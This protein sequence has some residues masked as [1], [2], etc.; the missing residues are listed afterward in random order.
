[1]VVAVIICVLVHL[2]TAVVGVLE[3]HLQ[4]RTTKHLPSKDHPVHS[5]VGA[6]VGA[7]VVEAVVEEAVVVE[8]AAVVEDGGTAVEV[9][10]VLLVVGVRVVGVVWRSCW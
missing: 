6:A 5:A 1:M 4:V 2:G 8:E 9:G 10:V 3:A 7:A